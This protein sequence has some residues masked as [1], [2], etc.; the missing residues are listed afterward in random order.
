MN[1]S[2]MVYIA[3][4]VMVVVQ[5]VVKNPQLKVRF[6]GVGYVSTVEDI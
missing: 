3:Q 4:V 2:I 5:I 1:V 6:T